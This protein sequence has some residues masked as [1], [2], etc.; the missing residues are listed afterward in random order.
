MNKKKKTHV[1]FR[2]NFLFFVVFLLFAALIMRLGVVQIVYGEDYQKEVNRTENMQVSVSVP[3]GVI[4]DREHR[5]IVDN[6]AKNAI[7]YT[8]PKGT[9]PEEMLELARTLAELIQQDKKRYDKITERDF[10]DYWILTRPDLADAKLS[11]EEKK[12]KKAYDILL[13]KISEEDLQAIKASDQELEVVSFFREMVAGASLTPKIL[14]KGI[15]NEELAVISEQLAS[16]P[17]IDIT[18]DWDRDP[19]ITILDSVLGDITSAD[20]G[21]P[22]DK[23][24]YYLARGYSRDDRVGK[25]QLEEQYEDVLSG[26]KKTISNVTDKAGNVLET[27]VVHDGTSGNDLILSIDFELQAEVEKILEEE[28]LTAKNSG[29]ATFLDRAYVVMLNPMTGEVLSLA[30]KTLKKDKD[31]FVRENGQYVV[32]DHA[33]GTFTSAYTMGSAVKGATVLT[34]FQKGL[35]RPGEH[36][37]DRTMYFKGPVKKSSYSTL[38]SLEDRNA[39]KKSSNVYM[40]NIA[41]RLMGV[42]YSPYM[43]LPL[44]PAALDEFRS[45]FHQFGLGVKTGIDLPSES[46]G[47]MGTL[48]NP[49]LMLDFAIGQ[50]DTYTPLQ[51]AQYVSTIANG[52]YRLQP[53]LVREIRQPTND[54]T[55]G[56]IAKSFEPVVLNKIDMSDEHLARV[57]EGFRRVMQESGGTATSFFGSAPYNSFNPAGKTGT[58]QSFIFERKNGKVIT[59]STYNLTLVGYAPFDKPEVAFSIVVPYLDKDT[60]P[61]NKKIGQRILAKY[62]ELKSK[63][64]PAVADPNVIIENDPNLEGETTE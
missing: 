33:L 30:G 10:K 56:A 60:N 41:L 29:G 21:L 39:L 52:G 11:A 35:I 59:H 34:G 9:K 32:D 13:D 2:L 42:S 51:L 43:S 25:S 5:V 37:Y 17:N 58:A 26:Q 22:A 44:R 47:Y 6:M 7:T 62:Y 31:K 64:G 63:N 1:P 54:D 53:Q 57:Q 18:T 61:V 12:E 3:R 50:F 45:Y 20:E 36:I 40:F 19:H 14:K 46:T 16:L 8:K 55:L 48:S 15:T 24:D 23:L 49:G 4:Y 38:G 28:L 27:K